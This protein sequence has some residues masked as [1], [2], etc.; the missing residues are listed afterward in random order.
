[1]AKKGTKGKTRKTSTKKAET[2]LPKRFL[3]LAEFCKRN[4]D[5]IVPDNLVKLLRLPEMFQAAYSKLKSNPGN[6]TPGIKPQTLDGISLEWVRETIRQISA[7]TFDFQPGRR[8]M[9]SKRDGKELRALTVAPPRDKIVQEVIRMILEAVFE[10]S[11][12]DNSHGFRPGRSCHTAMRQIR[13]QFGAASFY[14]EGDISKCFPSINHRNL[15]NVIEAKIKDR[16][17]TML[18]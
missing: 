17:F 18:I 3:K 11:F 15:M 16:Q 2:K 7:K 8:V 12:S 1:M 5:A 6:M 4:P 14:L 9:I 13:T 10:H